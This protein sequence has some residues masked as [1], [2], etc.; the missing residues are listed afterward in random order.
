MTNIKMTNSKKTENEYIL[1]TFDEDEDIILPNNWF[2]EI[3]L[4]FLVLIDIYTA[5]KKERPKKWMLLKRQIGF[6]RLWLKNK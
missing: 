4:I 1:E 2:E 5:P 3:Y 6:F